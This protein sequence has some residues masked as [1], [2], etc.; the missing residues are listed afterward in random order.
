VV[1]I[2]HLVIW[3]VEGR[4]GLK[5][6]G[7]VSAFLAADWQDVGRYTRQNPDAKLSFTL[8]ATKELGVHLLA[9]S[10]T[11]EWVHGLYMADYKRQSIPDAFV[12]DLVLRYRYA[13][14]ERRLMLEPYLLLRNF[15]DRNYAYV[16]G[17]PMPGFN[18]LLGLRVGL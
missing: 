4:V 13:S 12:M 9:A 3:G 15:L 18:A 1:N 8:E 14:P 7:P 16:A 11:G 6:L 17:Y 10:I 5:R 2:D